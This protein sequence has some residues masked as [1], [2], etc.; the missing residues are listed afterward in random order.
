MYI[1]CEG[2]NPCIKDYLCLIGFC[3]SL[4]KKAVMQADD[5]DID[6]TQQDVTEQYK[7]VERKAWETR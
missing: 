7:I 2:I 3:N 4:I 6:D 5:E 1:C